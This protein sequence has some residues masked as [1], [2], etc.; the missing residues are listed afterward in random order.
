MR[1][2]S[3]IIRDNN[4]GKERA[5]AENILPYIAKCNNDK[6]VFKC[7]FIGDYIPDGWEAIQNFFVDSTGWGRD[8]EPALTPENF[9]R[10]VKKGLGYAI[11]EK[12]QFQVYIT[13]FKKT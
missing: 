5:E 13:E 3:E 9:L 11:T 2:L 10:K 1:S 4:N 8:N 12:G 6:N 7:D